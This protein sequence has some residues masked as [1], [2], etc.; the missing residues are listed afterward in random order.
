MNK[1][2]LSIFVAA[3]MV[4]L[5]TSA[6]NANVLSGL[7]YSANV[8]LTYGQSKTDSKTFDNESGAGFAV[9]GQ[10]KYRIN[11]NVAINAG[12]G[13]NQ[14]N[15]EWTNDATKSTVENTVTYVNIPVTAEYTIP[16]QAGRFTFAV[17]G[18][19]YAG[20]KLS[21][22][23]EFKLDGVK[24]EVSDEDGIK[25][26]DFG[27]T[28]GASATTQTDLGAIKAITVAANY[29]VG[30][31]DINDADGDDQDEIKN[32]YLTAAISGQF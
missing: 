32:N 21:E 16:K 5:S 25:G 12:L 7:E 22:D 1:K 2:T 28:F 10:A 26:A 20:I 18:G 31:T 6:V 14:I 30:L 4:A 13:V 19:A 23:S 24:Q 3:V 17:E 27:L 8:G 29:N 9:Q 11:E 15:S